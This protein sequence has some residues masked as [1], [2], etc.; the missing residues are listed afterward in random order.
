[1]EH[2]F[3]STEFENAY[4]TDAPLGAFCTREGTLFHLWAPTAERVEL[5]LYR[6]GN[7]TPVWRTHPMAAKAQG[8]WAYEAPENLDG[9]Y[10]DYAVCV[11]GKTY[12]TPDPYGTACGVN[13]L[14]SMALDLSRTDP[15]NW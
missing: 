8:L 3:D 11:D 6:E 4:H 10:Y 2:I 13:G 1:M 5:R 7:G 15:E 14:R 12:E 9:V